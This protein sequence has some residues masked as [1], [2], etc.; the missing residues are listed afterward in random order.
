L[1]IPPFAAFLAM[2]ALMLAAQIAQAAGWMVDLAFVV[3]ACPLLIAGGLAWRVENR[4]AW[5]LGAVSFPLYAVHSPLLHWSDG[6]GLG[7]LPG[8]ACA[9]ALAAYIARRM[10]PPPRQSPAMAIA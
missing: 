1:R 7:P 3:I 4:T 6:L 10:N 8:I 9:L 2:P 5:W